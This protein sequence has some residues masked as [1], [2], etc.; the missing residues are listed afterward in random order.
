MWGNTFILPTSYN[1]TGK[2]YK[3]KGVM[4]DFQ[5]SIPTS[6]IMNFLGGNNSQNETQERS[7]GGGGLMGTVNNA[8]G[9]GQSGERN[10]GMTVFKCLIHPIYSCCFL[11][12]LDKGNSK[13]H[14]S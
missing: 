7:A 14:K 13:F 5:N 2:P 12:P 6:C 9:G 10:E 8:L 11:D 3:I 1:D 4:L